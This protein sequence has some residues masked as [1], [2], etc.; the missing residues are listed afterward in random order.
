ML[1]KNPLEDIKNTET[2]TYT[3]V[4][5]RL[6]DTSTMSEIGNTENNRK[7]FWWENSKA[8]EAFPR[9]EASQSFTVPG[10]GC[11]LSHQ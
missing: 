5:G 6:Y 3:M 4:N 10:C 1:E 8:S 9:H 7:Q 2:V 11:H